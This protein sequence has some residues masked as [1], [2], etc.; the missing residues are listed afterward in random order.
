MTPGNRVILNTLIEKYAPGIE[1][2][3]SSIEL[4]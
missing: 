3:E 1:V 4:S 2:A